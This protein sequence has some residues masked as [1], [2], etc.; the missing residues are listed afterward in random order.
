VGTAFVF[1]AGIDGTIIEV[2]AIYN[3][4]LA[5]INVVRFWRTVLVAL[6][7]GWV[8]D[9]VAWAFPRLESFFKDAQVERTQVIVIALR[10]GLFFV[11]T[12]ARYLHAKWVVHLWRVDALAVIDIAGIDSARIPVVAV[13]GFI[14]AGIVTA[15]INGAQV[16][17]VTIIRTVGAHHGITGFHV[18]TILAI[19]TL[20]ATLGGFHRF[21]SAATFVADPLFARL[22][23]LTA[24]DLFE[25]IAGFAGT[26]TAGAADIYL[27]DQSLV[28]PDIR[29]PLHAPQLIGNASI[30]SCVGELAF[31]FP[32]LAGR[33]T[34]D[35][36]VR[37]WDFFRLHVRFR[38]IRRFQISETV[39]G[40]ADTIINFW[41]D[42]CWFWG[43]GW[44]RTA[45]HQTQKSAAHE[46]SQQV[47]WIGTSD[48]GFLLTANRKGRFSAPCCIWFCP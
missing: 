43:C 29:A 23:G 27:A 3:F 44:C 40:L 10:M 16:E 7:A 47:F 31:D 11:C 35:W 12:P 6:F 8:K 42:V 24:T 33:N 26:K 30:F 45:H 38:L 28:A 25:V 39:Q 34:A 37:L 20:K 13:L 17:L 15:D 36:C 22:K 19:F 46:Q 1:V 21:G 18:H 14:L 2:V 4:R 9:R 5:E 32:F 48:H 41:D